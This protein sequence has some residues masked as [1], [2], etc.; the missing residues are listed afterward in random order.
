[1]TA[2][3]RTARA[4]VLDIAY[5]ETGDPGGP[6][7]ILLHGFPYDVRVYDE[8]VPP[9]AAAGLRVVVPYLRGFGPTRFA[10]PTTMRSG[11]QAA[12][13]H[14]LLE[15][16]DALAADTALVAGYDWGGRAACVLAALWPDRV[17]GLVSGGGYL[18]Q[19]IAAAGQP[20]SPVQERMLWYQYYFHGERGRAGL[21]QHRDELCE[22]LWRTWSPAWDG[23]AEAFARSAAS[24]RNPDFTEVVLHSYRHRYGLAA[25]DP[26]Y[27]HTEDRLARLP[28][29]T[30]PAVV[31]EGG[32]N[33]VQPAAGE[34]G[35]ARFTGPREYV[36]LPGT[37]H[38]LP[39]EAPRAFADAV[40][41]LA[42]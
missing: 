29:I 16:I 34:A 33:G 31:L 41:S 26:R 12:I 7:A 28:E 39:Q 5:E 20:A 11:Q 8:V 2:L 27:Q 32:E 4:G 19:D 40:L 10:G 37:G 23:A 15:L 9:L 3:I 21:E 24:L 35:L 18:I 30:G 42:R 36:F 14:D 1:V 13:A 25:G 17:R 38:N 6:V 22:L